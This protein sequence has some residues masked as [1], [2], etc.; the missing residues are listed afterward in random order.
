GLDT[1]VERK[2]V[3]LGKPLIHD[4]ALKSFKGKSLK[5]F[6]R[7][8]SDEIVSTIVTRPRPHNQV[9][10]AVAI[11][12]ARALGYSLAMSCKESRSICTYEGLKVQMTKNAAREIFHGAKILRFV[13]FYCFAFTYADFS[14]LID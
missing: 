6:R 4:Y 1:K 14:D 10:N 2:R 13:S 3:A 9:G 7:L 5:P 11:P 12:V 8:W